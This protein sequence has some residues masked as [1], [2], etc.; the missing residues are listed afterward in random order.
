MHGNLPA[1]GDRQAT[2]PSHL[3]VYLPHVNAALV[4]KQCG[5]GQKEQ[6]LSGAVHLQ[7]I[8]RADIFEPVFLDIFYILEKKSVILMFICCNHK[9]LFF[10]SKCTELWQK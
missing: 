5:Y 2:C 7:R 9:L 10:F 1:E 3:S 4:L 6:K 8:T